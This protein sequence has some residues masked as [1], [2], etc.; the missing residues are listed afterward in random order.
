M[1]ETFNMQGTDKMHIKLR[2]DNLEE[3]DYLTVIR[4]R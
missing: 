1:N 3:G 2:S 4:K